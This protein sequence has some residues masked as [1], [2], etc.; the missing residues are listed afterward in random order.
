MIIIMTMT[1][2]RFQ[3]F[4]VHRLVVVDRNEVVC[5]IISL[6]DIL[7]YLILIPGGMN[8]ELLLKYILNI[9][10]LTL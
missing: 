6:S 1:S 4:Q 8:E 2:F 7:N 5:G 9:A 10:F 3:S